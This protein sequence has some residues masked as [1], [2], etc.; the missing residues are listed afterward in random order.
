[1]R[2]IPSMNRNETAPDR[3]EISADFLDRFP[4]TETGVRE[5]PWR[6]TSVP[7]QSDGVKSFANLFDGRPGRL[8]QHLAVPHEDERRPQFDL[9]GSAQRLPFAILDHD[10][11]DARILLKKSR[12]LRP[13]CAAIGSPFRAE[14]KE[15]WALHPVDFLPGRLA[16]SVP[17]R[18]FDCHTLFLCSGL[19]Q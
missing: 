8:L 2:G 9:K 17:A 12:Q 11:S 4:Y 10:V 16:F 19:G 14:F 6:C 1:M 3:A 5:C 13:K 15:D 18:L 7:G